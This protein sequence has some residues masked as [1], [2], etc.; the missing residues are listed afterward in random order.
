VTSENA[1]ERMSGHRAYV[2]I[3]SIVLTGF[4]G[5]GKTTV[6]ELLAA[7]LGWRFV[8][9]DRAVEERARMTVGEIFERHGEAAFREMEA[10]AIRE[11]ASGE[12][13]VLALGGGALELAETREWL[14]GLPACRTIFLDAPL[15]VLLA[16]CAD[17]TGG[18]VRPVLRDRE[19]LAQRWQTRLPWYRHAHLT[20]A[21]QERTPQAVVDCVLAALADDTGQSFSGPAATRGVPA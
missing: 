20:I 11:T 16:R 14:A 15:E 9:T 18:P 4:M 12:S 19:R 13:L 7:R 21:T 5:A 3:S 10:T 17:H 6:G 8:D 2:T 1:V